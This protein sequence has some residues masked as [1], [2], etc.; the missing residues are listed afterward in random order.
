[1]VAEL[2]NRLKGSTICIYETELCG[3]TKGDQVK[4]IIYNWAMKNVVLIE[5][6]RVAWVWKYG[7]GMVMINFTCQPEQLWHPY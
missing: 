6:S 3:C 4:D 5:S 7:I 2:E 1:M